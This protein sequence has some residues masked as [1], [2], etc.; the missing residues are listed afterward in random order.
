MQDSHRG[1][2][3]K[4]EV[5]EDT[6]E[7]LR[8]AVIGTG[9]MGRCLSTLLKDHAEVTLHSRDIKKAR[10]IARRI[11]VD[12]ADINAISGSDVILATIPTGALQRFVEESAGAMRPGAIFVDVSSV[13]VG[14]VE[15]VLKRLP[16]GTGYVSIHPLF[17]SPK[18]KEK[19]VAFIPVRETATVERFLETLSKSGMSVF[20]T[21]AEEHDRATAAT[22]VL[23]HFAL[24]T[25]ERV[26]QRYMK[27]SER[28]KT[29]SLRK[30]L[31]VIRLVE[32]N[33]ETAVMIQKLNKFGKGIREEFIRE[34]E[35]LDREFSN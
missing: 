31:A 29:H 11:G 17:T 30:T 35:A 23:H 18:V 25:M 21:T 14:L 12:G 4:D 24:L 27:S 13:K 28:F 6:G 33:R 32:R 19:G 7:L 16:K 22:Q 26:L 15:E 10:A 9:K 34:A 1:T 3:E 5:P 8:V 20:R 2:E